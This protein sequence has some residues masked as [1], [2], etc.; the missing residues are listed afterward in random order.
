MK[1][2]ERGIIAF[3]F[4]G[5]LASCQ[6]ANAPVV[7]ETTDSPTCAD[8]IQQ[9]KNALST[10]NKI[11]SECNEVWESCQYANSMQDSLTQMIDLSVCSE[12]QKTELASLS[13]RMNTKFNQMIRHG[14]ET[15]CCPVI[16]L[17]IKWTKKYAPNINQF[18]NAY[19]VHC[20]PS[21]QTAML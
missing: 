13:E 11:P 17:M 3:V 1:S 21:I 16:A 2:V 12:D 6:Q 4:I 14:I 18:A 19:K 9:A 7:A 8:K 20:S 15:H 5:L 10:L